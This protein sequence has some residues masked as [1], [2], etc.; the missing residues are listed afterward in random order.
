MSNIYSSVDLLDSSM[1]NIYQ[2]VNLLDTSINQLEIKTDYSFNNVD[3]SND[4][5]IKNLNVYDKLIDLSNNGTG[6]SSSSIDDITGLQSALDSKQAII[7]T[8]DL[9]ISDTN[10]LQSAL[11][12]KQATLT[13]STNLNV[14][15]ITCS[16]FQPTNINGYDAI[17][18]VAIAKVM[19]NGNL[20]YGKN[21]SSSRSSTGKYSITFNNSLPT[22]SFIVQLSVVE[23]TSSRDDVIITLDFGSSSYNGFSYT[24]S[25]QDN[26][27]TAGTLQDR[28]NFVAVFI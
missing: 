21:C 18:I 19:A 6:S 20:E 27:D 23:S 1:S 17:T 14:D 4:L 9:A 25:E 22:K 2:L 26:G 11:D 15:T 12:S 28:V 7:N 16:N 3:I 24:I 10:G 5:Y 8:N 13:T